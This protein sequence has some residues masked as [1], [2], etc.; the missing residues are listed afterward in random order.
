MK[1]SL[2]LL[3][4]IASFAAIALVVYVAGETALSKSPIFALVPV[5]ILLVI[6]V[7]YIRSQDKQ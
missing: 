1:K 6:I 7:F 2:K 4:I 3:L 5:A